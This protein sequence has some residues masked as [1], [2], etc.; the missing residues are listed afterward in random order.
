MIE[1]MTIQISSTDPV[2][3]KQL[4]EWLVKTNPD[5]KQT[6][7]HSEVNVTKTRLKRLRLQETC[8][9]QVHFN[10]SRTSNG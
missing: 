8:P 5:P 9:S 2:F 10:F 1:E 3:M 6:T 4:M 7:V